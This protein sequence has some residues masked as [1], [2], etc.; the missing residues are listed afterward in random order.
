MTI[1]AASERAARMP[2]TVCAS[3]DARISAAAAFFAAIAATVLASASP[4]PGR[5]AER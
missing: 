1:S 2:S 4:G 3:M 5:A